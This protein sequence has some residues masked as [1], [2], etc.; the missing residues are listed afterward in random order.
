MFQWVDVW[1]IQ[2]MFLFNSFKYI[3]QLITLHPSRSLLSKYSSAWP[4]VQFCTFHFDFDK[5]FKCSYN[6]FLSSFTRNKQWA[7]QI[8]AQSHSFVC[9]QRLLSIVMCLF[10]CIM[11]WKDL[12][13]C[14]SMMIMCI[15]LYFTLIIWLKCKKTK[16]PPKNKKK[17]EYVIF[18]IKVINNLW[19][20]D[21]LSEYHLM[22]LKMVSKSEYC[23]LCKHTECCT[24]LIKLVTLFLRKI[25]KHVCKHAFSFWCWFS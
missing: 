17:T 11:W 7:I 10:C 15:C 4:W 5:T 24:C 19:L 14:S 21:S 22:V 20:H 6:F 2:F 1:I 25:V 12:H 9:C 8:F 3:N 18:Q 16:T 23:C 13:E